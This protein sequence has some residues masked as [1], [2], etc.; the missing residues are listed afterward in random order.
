MCFGGRSQVGRLG[1]NSAFLLSPSYYFNGRVH[2][3]ICL[4]AFGNM[5]SMYDSKS[6]RSQKVQQ[7]LSYTRKM[8]SKVSGI[9][10]VSDKLSTQDHSI[11]SK[12]N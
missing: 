3:R 10:Q 8:S 1:S 4:G 5:I 9:T 7:L 12:L 11:R 2:Y 6:G